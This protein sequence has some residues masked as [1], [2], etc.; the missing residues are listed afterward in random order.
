MLSARS[1]WAVRS[2]N[3]A[4]TMTVRDVAPELTDQVTRTPSVE[5]V[6]LT[7]ARQG[8]ERSESATEASCVV[9]R[10]RRVAETPTAIR[11]TPVAA[12]EKTATE[13]SESATMT[14]TRANARRSRR[15]RVL[16]GMVPRWRRATRVASSFERRSD[17]FY[18]WRQGVTAGGVR[19]VAGSGGRGLNV[20]IGRRASYC[21][22]EEQVERGTAFACAIDPD[23][24]AQTLDEVLNHGQAKPCPFK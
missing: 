12:S 10:V 24:T 4:L 20:E 22:W 3:P 16:L 19:L 21:D 17:R 15:R 23:G 14:S 7:S 1:V 9:A 18:A 2:R 13:S 6:P 11:R 8:T 5:S